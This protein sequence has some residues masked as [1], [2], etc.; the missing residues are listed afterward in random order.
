MMGQFRIFSSA[1]WKV[2]TKAIAISLH[3][4]AGVNTGGGI[5]FFL[6]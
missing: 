1:L 5:A 2:Q 4:A 3:Y 6:R